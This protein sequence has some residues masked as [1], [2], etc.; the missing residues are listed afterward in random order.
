MKAAL[1]TG[2]NQI[3]IRNVPD[4][5][6]PEGGVLVE[7]KNAA[8]CGTDVKMIK[9]GH[10]DLM[11]PRIPG[12]EG[13]GIVV[14]SRNEGFSKGDLVAVYPGIFCGRC[15]NCLSGHTARC[16]SI[17][18]YGFNR[19]GLFRSLVPFALDELLG[20]VKMSSNKK[21][22]LSVLA[23]P[24]ACCISG[25]KK[26]PVEKGTA[27]I[28]GAGSVGSI[29]AALLKAKGWKRIVIADRDKERL[30][31]NIP[32]YVETIETDASSIQLYLKEN[33][34]FDLIVPC[35]PEGLDWDFWKYLKPGGAVILFS[36]NNNFVKQRPVDLNEMHYREITLA[37]SYGCNMNDFED[38]V[39]MIEKSEIDL[40]FL[41][42]LRISMNDLQNAVE[43]AVNSTVKKIIIE[44]F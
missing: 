33:D 44:E 12:H 15:Q 26:V 31:N 5:A 37:G 42:P 9:H 27:L 17:K 22:T 34:C 28:F 43:D 23:E 36:G 10:R 25:Y 41:N 21:N 38:A 13:T 29:F 16:K 18:I 35:C 3:E 11:L 14:E 1:I 4:P 20:L 19:D 39:R 30:E 32:E 24:L 6:V 2:L 8:V 7:M 40:S